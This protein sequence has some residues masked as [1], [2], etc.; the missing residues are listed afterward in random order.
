MGGR[1][2]R[3]THHRRRLRLRHCHLLLHLLPL[4]LF[5]LVTQISALLLCANSLGRRCLPP[6][7]KHRPIAGKQ[8]SFPIVTLSDE[9]L[10]GRSARGR[11]FRGVLAATARNKRAYAATHGYR[12]AVLPPGAVDPRRLPAWSKILALRAHLGRH[13]W[14]FWNDALGQYP[15]PTTHYHSVLVSCSAT[16]ETM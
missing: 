6:A 14:L 4:L 7:A 8:L 16:Q 11:Y 12:L 3:A 1:A 2:R 9:G 10:A 5:F 13:H 15:L